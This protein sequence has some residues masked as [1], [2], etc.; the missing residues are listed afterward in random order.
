VALRNLSNAAANKEPI[1]GCA[2]VREALVVGAAAGQRAVVREHALGALC[3]LSMAEAN[4]LSM[5]QLD[6][7]ALMDASN[8]ARITNR[9]AAARAERA[10]LPAAVMEQELRHV[11]QEV[12]ALREQVNRLKRKREE[13]E[14]A[15]GA[16]QS[17]DDC[18]VCMDKKKTDMFLP[19]GHRCVCAACAQ[20]VSGGAA[21]ACPI[22][23][24]PIT[25]TMRVYN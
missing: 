23:R 19:C 15:A 1:W 25:G 7:F 17:N 13:G 22:C 3:I 21:A 20:T 6:V 10:A 11:N 9:A 18:V 5:E 4:L 14:G 8:D 16:G 12:S 2:G 24:K